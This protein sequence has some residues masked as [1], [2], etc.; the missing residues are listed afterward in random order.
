[1]ANPQ[2]TEIILKDGQFVRRT[3]TEQDLGSQEAVLAQCAN[4]QKIYL[5][6]IH[7][8]SAGRQ[9]NMLSSKSALVM[10]T[11][12]KHLPFK[13]Y[14]EVAEDNP[15][16]LAPTFRPHKGTILLDDP[17]P[18]PDQIG[19]M[20]FVLAYSQTG[21]VSMPFTASTAHLFLESG[22]EL[23][24][25][26]YPNLFEDG[27]LCMGDQWDARRSRNVSIF[28]D[29]ERALESF[30]TSEMNDHLVLNASFKMFRKDLSGKWLE[31]AEDYIAPGRI[32]R[33]FPACGVVFMEGY[34]P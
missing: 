28:D 31:P 10:I 11:Q 34:V 15:D 25:I 13:T 2:L 4:N 22:G 6:N 7:H 14:F 8:D 24:K 30:H 33:A 27:R 20:L 21:R 19:K 3:V 23:R 18:V 32:A 17:W 26:P 1:M 29:F 5:R 9:W 16:Q 12:L